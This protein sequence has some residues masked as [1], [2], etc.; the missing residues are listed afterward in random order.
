MSSPEC[1]TG[2][3]LPE[4][5]KWQREKERWQRVRRGRKWVDGNL[6][7]STPQSTLAAPKSAVNT[8]KDISTKRVASNMNE[9]LISAHSGDLQISRSRCS[10]LKWHKMLTNIKNHVYSIKKSSCLDIT[11]IIRNKVKFINH[12]KAHSLRSFFKRLVLIQMC[13]HD[14]TKIRPEQQTCQILDTFQ[15]TSGL[16]PR[17]QKLLTKLYKFKYDV[18]LLVYLWFLGRSWSWRRPLPSALVFPPKQIN[19]VSLYIHYL[20]LH[21]TL[22]SVCHRK[23]SQKCWGKDWKVKVNVRWN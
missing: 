19:R 16:E 2:K 15:Y 12:I 14:S 7:F 11:Y 6:L 3:R 17:R 22:K 8:P 23:Q 21:L 4:L 5:R 10:L 13:Q 1:Q 20:T 18:Y 9:A